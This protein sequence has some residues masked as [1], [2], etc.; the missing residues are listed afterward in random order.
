MK[1][2]RVFFFKESLK[3]KGEGSF[4]PEEEGGWSICED[5]PIRSQCKECGGGNICKHNRTRHQERVQEMQGRQGRQER[6]A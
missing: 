1:S 6:S 4:S 3:R 5:N 2:D